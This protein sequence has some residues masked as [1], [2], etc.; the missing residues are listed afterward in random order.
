MI[1]TAPPP[2][3]ACRRQARKPATAGNAVRH[4]RTGAS[5]GGEDYL[6]HST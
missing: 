6:D 5:A 1:R 3:R 2:T 4:E